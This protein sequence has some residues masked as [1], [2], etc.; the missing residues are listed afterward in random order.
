M[1]HATVSRFPKVLSHEYTERPNHYQQAVTTQRLPKQK[2]QQNEQKEQ[3]PIRRFWESA[4]AAQSNL[5]LH[6]HARKD[7]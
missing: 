4:R 1:L 6:Q 2:K 3:W 7:V 5:Q